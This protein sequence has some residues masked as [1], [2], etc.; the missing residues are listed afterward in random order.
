MRK[1]IRSRDLSAKEK[2]Q[3]HL[4]SYN[5]GIGIVKTAVD[6]AK[7]KGVSNPKWKNLLNNVKEESYLYKAIPSSWGKSEKY[8][9]VTE[10]VEFI[11][12]RAEQ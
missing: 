11:I 8:K 10:Y 2:L 6:K 9:E 7:S 12:K 5:L 3:Y 4:A 1:Y